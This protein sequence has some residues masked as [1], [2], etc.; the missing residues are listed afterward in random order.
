MLAKKG[1][2]HSSPLVTF[3]AAAVAGYTMF[4]SNNKLNMQVS[5]VFLFG[6]KDRFP[7]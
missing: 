6:C 3:L 5:G 2:G 4:G 7:H 1:M